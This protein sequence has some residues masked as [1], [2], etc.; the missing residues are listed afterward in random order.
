MTI[1]QFEIIDDESAAIETSRRLIEL[2]INELNTDLISQGISIESKITG[3]SSV[4]EF[5][6]DIENRF[7]DI[8]V[9]DLAFE[10]AYDKSGW[11]IIDEI[12]K[13]E[14]VPVVVYS[15][16]ADDPLP[17][18]EFY[19]N[20]LIIRQRKGE[21]STD[22]YKEILKDVILLKLN[23]ILEKERLLNEF[24]QISLET[25]KKIINEVTIHEI[26]RNILSFLALTR[27]TSLLLN[28]PPKDGTKFPPESIFIYPPLNHKTLSNNCVLLGDI[29]ECKEENDLKGLWLVCSPSCDLVF[30]DNE[31]GR[32]RKIN[33]ILLLP[34]Y[35]KPSEVRFYSGKPDDSIK[36][37][38]RESLKNKTSKLLKCPLNV[39]KSPY[40]LIYFKEY[41]T[42][43]YEI[44]K[45]HLHDRTWDKIASLATP[46][47]ESLQNSFV[48]DFS[49]IGTPDTTSEA[50]ERSWIDDFLR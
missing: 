49:R 50:E 21:E 11:A 17:A 38:L 5:K 46:Y 31:G 39:F 34:C 16:H 35:K 44:I 4:H 2:N 47:A 42:V 26:D 36:S 40:L 41:R 32:K 3:F 28:V 37:S 33:D 19:K 8:I 9:A 1:L 10:S 7:P 29:L 48:H 45:T 13:R 22:S 18:D 43:N 14:I 25:C 15:A 20:F 30:N 23:F 27:L 24:A 6:A 12:V